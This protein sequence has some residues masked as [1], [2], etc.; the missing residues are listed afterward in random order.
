VLLHQNHISQEIM[1][2]ILPHLALLLVF[3]TPFYMFDSTMPNNGTL[4][5]N[6]ASMNGA[7]DVK[8]DENMHFVLVVLT[9]V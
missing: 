7:Y 4:G 1:V 6:H 3:M 8:T 2:T 9:F 5:N